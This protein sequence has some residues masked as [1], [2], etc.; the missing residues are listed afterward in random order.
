MLMHLLIRF[1]HNAYTLILQTTHPSMNLLLE[2]AVYDFSD[3]QSYSLCL[4]RKFQISVHIGNT[5]LLTIEA[6]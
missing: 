2:E 1:K 3:N 6:P 5:I 4:V